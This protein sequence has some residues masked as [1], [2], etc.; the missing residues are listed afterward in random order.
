MLVGTASLTLSALH[1]L[2]TGSPIPLVRV[3]PLK[4]PVQVRDLQQAGLVLEDG[5]LHP[6][7]GIQELP[8]KSEVFKKA[9]E[10]GVEVHPDGETWGL[11]RV[12]HWCGNDP[13]MYD[14][15]RVNLSELAAVLHPDGLADHV[16]PDAREL[17][18]SDLPKERLARFGSR[19][20]S[21]KNLFYL[22]QASYCFNYDAF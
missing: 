8:L 12:Q 18:L 6:L 19:G 7:P 10:R 15:R 9:I 2:F 5:R 4:A 21:T 1:L 17:Y 11:L 3:Q 20:W 16:N 13:Y 22:G 14:L